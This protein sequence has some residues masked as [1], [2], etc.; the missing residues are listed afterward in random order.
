[1][2][3]KKKKKMEE[4]GGAGGDVCGGVDGRNDLEVR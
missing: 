2:K 4:K 3:K 1:M